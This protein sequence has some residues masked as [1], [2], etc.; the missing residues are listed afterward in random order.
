MAVRFFNTLS[1]SLEPFE[2]VSPGRVGVYA[3][4]PTVYDHAHVG[5]FR[6]FVF[7][8][9]VHRFLEWRGYPVHFVMNF[10]DVDDKTIRAA[11]EEGATVAEYTEP[12]TRAI[13]DEADALGIRRA[14]GYP[15]AT[16]YV[17][18]MVALVERLL[19]RGHAYTT[20]DG[21]VFFDITSFPEYGKLSRK[22]LEKG[23]TG[24]RVADDE[25]GKDDVR[26]FALWKAAKEEDRAVGAVWPAPW[27]EGRPGWH[28]ECSAMSLAEVGETVDI[29]LGGEDLIF[30]HH[31]DEIAQSEG[32]TG[33]PFVRCW[34]HVK[35][36]R[37]AD[38]KMSKSAGNTVTVRELLSRGTD[39]AA[40]RYHLLSAHYRTE[41][42]FGERGLDGSARAV[43]RW[44]DFRDR[45]R[46][47]EEDPSAA[48]AGLGKVAEE[49]VASFQDAMDEDLNVP[50]ALG[51]LFTLVGEGNGILDRVGDRIPSEEARAVLE[52]LSSMDEVLGVMEL[53]DRGRNV[54]EETRSWV[55]ERIREREEARERKDFQRADAIRDELAREGIVVEDSPRGTRWKRV[56]G[57][58]PVG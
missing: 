33:K 43:R 32:A 4:G 39:P 29:H 37:M 50:A 31:E 24:E 1:R 53:V 47:V 10:T 8:D 15:R 12:F 51:S 20:D 40:L 57:E 23:R 56:R 44:S 6:S 22:D 19:E 41:L 46:E 11:R 3:C 36:L 17:D 26:D 55:E 38:A 48:S 13:L 28:L 54:D 30:P 16:E 5:N 52:A 9:L 14:D 35:H 49:A 2:P 7:Y 27:G 34:L 42:A 45:V 18:E 25:Y 58:S 21:S